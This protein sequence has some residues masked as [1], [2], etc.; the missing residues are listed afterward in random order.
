[1]QF[2]LQ[3]SIDQGNNILTNI[4]ETKHSDADS[5]SCLH[6]DIIH[7][8]NTAKYTFRMESSCQALT[9]SRWYIFACA[10]AQIVNLAYRVDQEFT[11][12][13]NERVSVIQMYF[14]NMSVHTY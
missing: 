11:N 13:E 4:K 7:T 8:R 14:Q 6:Y 12:M 2:N 1:M 5:M 9:G 3:R 10:C